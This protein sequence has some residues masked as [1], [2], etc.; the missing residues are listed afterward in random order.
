MNGRQIL[1]GKQFS[2]WVCPALLLGF[3]L[4]GTTLSV[5][6]GPF[7]LHWWGLGRNK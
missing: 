3:E 1:K 2:L 7:E 6:V 5:W 4:G